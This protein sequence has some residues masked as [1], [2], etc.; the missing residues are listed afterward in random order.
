MTSVDFLR[1]K[2]ETDIDELKEI[3][4]IDYEVK[5]QNE[6]E[7]SLHVEFDHPEY[8]TAGKDKILMRIPPNVLYDSTY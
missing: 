4:L 3:Q 5:L 6:N 8:I 2:N 1:N 7:V